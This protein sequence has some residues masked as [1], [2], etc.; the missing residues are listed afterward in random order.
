MDLFDWSTVDTTDEELLEADR[1]PQVGGRFVFH[2]QPVTRRR[3]ARFGLDESVY[4]THVRQEGAFASHQ[5][6]G[7]ALVQALRT[8]LDTLLQEDTID[9]GDRIYLQLAS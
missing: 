8:S 2:L 3:S 5:N 1:T 7:N 9:D 4:D 6:Q